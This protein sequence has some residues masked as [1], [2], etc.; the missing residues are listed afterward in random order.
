MARDTRLAQD[1]IFHLTNVSAADILPAVEPFQPG[2]N[3]SRKS[4]TSYPLVV[5]FHAAKCR[6]ITVGRVPT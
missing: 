1:F 5:L 4:R 3:G 2:G 6:P